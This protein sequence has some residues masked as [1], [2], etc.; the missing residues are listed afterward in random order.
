MKKVVI[1]VLSLPLAACVSGYAQFYKPAP[2]ATQEA[3][4]KTRAA[5]PPAVPIVE[6]SAMPLKWDQY[7]QRGY[8]SIGYSSFNSGHKESEQNAIAQAQKVGAD[9]VVIINPR[10]TGSVT[11][12]IPITTPTAETSYS[13]GSATA[14]GAGGSVTA[15]GNST[16]T[17][18]GSRTDYIPITTNRFDYG[19]V[20]FVKRKY[21]LGVNWRELTNEE[22]SA[23]Q[24]NSGAYVT[25]VVDGTPAFR[26]DILAG[27]IITKVNGQL[28][29]GPQAASD[30]L[31]GHEGQ[32]I[33]MTIERKGQVIEKKVKLSN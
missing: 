15:Y 23:R 4:A 21:V 12:Q 18:Y 30:A 3:I 31:R 2:G 5:P 7:A 20:Y 16:T 17:T 27:D 11:S 28:I 6:Y 26:S 32:E 8:A 19:A 29:Y 25:S 9:L 13:N 14:Y 10:Y 22:R 1:A 24:S 33:D